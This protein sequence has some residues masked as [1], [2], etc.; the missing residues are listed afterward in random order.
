MS[1]L[2]LAPVPRAALVALEDVGRAW[3]GA[4]GIAILPECTH[5]DGVAAHRGAFAEEI[6]QLGV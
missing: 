4:I 1:F 2:Y 3:L 5:D 6:A